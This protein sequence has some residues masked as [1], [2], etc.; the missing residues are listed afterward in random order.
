MNNSVSFNK[1]TSESRI[2]QNETV[3]IITESPE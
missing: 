3:M 1:E 2:Q